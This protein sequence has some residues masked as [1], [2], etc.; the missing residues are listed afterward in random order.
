MDGV[1]DEK[2]ETTCNC[3]IYP[4]MVLPM[5]SVPEKSRLLEMDWISVEGI[6]MKIETVIID[7]GLLSLT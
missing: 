1:C 6:T 2:V 5:K 4:Y 3:N 7:N